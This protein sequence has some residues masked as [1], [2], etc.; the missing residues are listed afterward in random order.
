[1]ELY[2]MNKQHGRMILESVEN[3]PLIWPSIEE[4]GVTKPKKYSDLSAT[5]AIQADCDV[6]ATNII[7]Q[8]LPLKVYALVSNHKVAK[9][10]WE[11][12]Q[13]LMQGT[14][15][16]KQEREMILESV[17]NGPL[18]WPSIEENRV[19]KP[20]KYS[21]LSATE[22]IQAD[23]D[24]KATNIIL[25]GL[26]LKYGSPYQSQQYSHNQSST[27]LS[28]TFPPNDFQSS[29]HHNVYSPSS[30]TP[31][32]EYAP[33]VNQRPKFSQPDSGLIVL[34]FQK[35]DDPIDAINYMMSFLTVVV[36]SRGDTSLAAG[37]S[38]TYTPGAS[39]NNSRK[40]R[41][42]ICYNCK[43]EGHMSK[44]SKNCRSSTHTDCHHHIVA[45]Q[46]N[47]LDAYDSDC[48]EINTAT[49]TLMTN[50][51]HYGSENLAEVHNH[52]N[53][54]HNVINQAMQ[55]MLCSEQSN[56]VNHLETEITS[57]NNII[58]YSQYVS[59]SQ[60]AA[61]QNSNSPAQQDALI[62]YVIEQLKTQV[63]NCTKISLDNKSVN[64]TSTVELERY[65]DQ[66][67]QQLK[68]KLYD[69]NIIEKTNAI[70]IRDS[71]ET[72]MLT[73]ES[74]SKMLLK[75]KDHMMSEKKVNTTLVDYANYVN[76]LEPT[77][78]ARPT[79]VK[80]PKELPKVSM[81]N[82]SLKK[83]KH[84]LASFDVVVKERN[85]ATSITKGT[86]GLEHTKACFRDEIIPFVKA[87]KGLFNSF[88]QF[89]VD[90]L[91]EV[92]NVFHQMEQAVE[93]H[94]VES[95][96]FEVKMNK[97]LSEN[98][99]LL[100]QV[101]SKDIVNILVNSSVNNA[102]ET[103]HECCD[104]LALVD[105]F[106]PIEDNIVFRKKVLVIT[107][108]KDKLRKLKGKAIVDDVVPS[109]PIDPELLKVDVAPLAPKL[110]N[111]RTVHSYYLRHTQEETTTLREIVKQG[112]LLNPLNNSLDYACKYTK[113]IQELLIIIRQTCPC[114][115]NFGDKLMVVTP[116]NKTKRVRFT[117]PVTSSRNT[118]IKTASSSNV[119]SNKPLLSSIGVNLSTSASGSHP[120]GNTK[121]DK[122]QQTPSSTKKNKIK[123]Y[124]RTVRSS[125]INK[126]CVV[127]PKDTT[128]VQHSN[129][130]MNSDLQCITCHGCMFS[131]N[132][133][134]CVLDFI[135]NVN[136]RVK[137]KFAK[138]TVKKKFGN[139]QER[140][141]S[142]TKEQ[143]QALDE[144]L[145]P[146]EQRLM[147]GSCNYRLSTTFKPK[148]PTF[149]VTLD[150]LSLTP[151]Y[152]AFLI[153]MC[154]KHPG[155]KFVDPPFEEDILT[156]MR[157]LGYS[158]HI[159]FLS[160]IKV[161]TLPQPWRTF[162]TL[163]NKC[164]SVKT[165]QAPK[166][167]LGK[168]IKAMAKVA[169]SGKKKQPALGLETL[170]E[171]ALNEAEQLK[172][173]TK[174]S[175]IQTH[176]SHASGSEVS[177]KSSNEEDDD[178]EANIS[179]D[180]DDNDQEDDD[181]TNHDDEARK[182]EEVNKEESFDPIVQN[183]LK[184]KALMMKTMMMIVMRS[185]VSSRFVLNM[186]N[187]SPDTGI[188]STFNLNI[189]LTP[190]VDALVTTAAEPPLLYAI[191][192]LLPSTPIIPHL[193]QTHV[194]L[195]V[196]VPSSSLQ[197][198]PNFGSLFR[199]DHR[200]KTL[201][202]IDNRMN[203]AVKVAV[204][205]Q[206]ERLRDETQVENE[207]FLNKLDENIQKLIKEQL[208][209]QVKA[210][211][212]KILPK[213]KKTVNE[214]LKAEVLTRSYKSSKTSH[215]VAAKLSEL[216]LKKILID[217][218][219]N[220]VTLKRRRDDEDKDEEPS[221]RSNWGFKRRIAGKEQESTSAP[222]KKTSKTTSKSTEGSK[223]HHKSASESA[224]AEEPMH[225]TKDL[226]E[227]AHQEFDTRATEDQP[228]LPATHG[229]IQPWISNLA[230]KDDSNNS[231]NEMMDTPLDFSA[232]VMNRL[233]VDTLTPELLAEVYKETTDQLDW[234]NPEG[235][236][237]LHDLRKPLPLIP[238]SRGRRVIPFDHFINND[239]EYLLGGVSSRKYTTSVTKTKASDYEYIKWI[240]DLVPRT[241]WSQVP[242]SYDKPA[243]WKSH[244]GGE[245][246]NI[247]MDLR[248][249][250]NLL[251]IDD[252]KLYKFK[253][254]DYNRLRIQDIEDMLLL[255]V[256]GKLTNLT[257][258][259][260]F[261]FNVS[262]RISDLKRK[263]AY[264]TYSNPIGFIYQ[265]NDKQNRLMRIDELHKFS[266][267]TLND[268][269][270]ALDDRLK[271]IRMQY[272]PQTIWT[273]SDK[274]RADAMIQSIDKQLK[275]RR[276][277][278][279]LEK[280]I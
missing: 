29:V 256:Q 36:T 271:G 241:M 144:A 239:F 7:L 212:S 211:V 177:W 124:P 278:R 17:E 85:T 188:D 115:N 63:V 126:K 152:P 45:Y 122:I 226:E 31:Q 186:L 108:L 37:T 268:V 132:H 136:A 185:F 194:P 135:N 138:K 46:A 25:Q 28:I 207:D 157:E 64:D 70:M 168:I 163:I 251:E 123:A 133:D 277:I 100:E 44:Q 5:E 72:L 170:T 228:T 193:Q 69:G 62:F 34:V 104:P 143:Q 88:D 38:R 82:T 202:Y 247:S 76:S 178:D 199:F 257:V 1:M 91:S 68:P 146:R 214:Q 250:G 196:N 279:S 145:I 243:L 99:R 117:E 249:T 79:K 149:Q 59:E 93:Q 15:L 98:E 30:S 159:K 32:V 118:N 190:R 92:Q 166:P 172:L 125:L 233:K 57:D 39:G 106:I 204:Q 231:F 171:V 51:S 47:D 223:S 9:E 139:Q 155:Q 142:I 110:W 161:D 154:P 140:I 187:I 237:Y 16:T 24:V 255:L 128:S 73:E 2:M 197:D 236:Q 23:C 164:L 153:T 111:N 87:L 267:G 220:T 18:I 19:T 200:L 6:K 260:S 244:I 219:E 4:N 20:K 84:H 48:D 217:K 102:Y 75:Q 40:Q 184:L 206:S 83:L 3:G 134:S 103:V 235:Q 195:P 216:E 229:P 129:L 94:R 253:E 270:T 213:I 173:S 77:P 12:I 66:K 8:G 191:T 61:V 165:E 272:L 116:M 174:Q 27:P 246:N 74:C 80:V 245:N 160:D 222:N 50:L 265:N 148:E 252:D 60:Q 240:E 89:L 162:G 201:E 67:A 215:V 95:K 78:S 248:L 238:T 58:P 276:I 273:R 55:A 43:G 221:A 203:E 198:L 254:G 35:G 10:L 127:K 54:N 167:F 205:L 264:T 13:L 90:E 86:W 263:E 259:E 150:V 21:D 81:V 22:A 156:F 183:L 137:S 121:K 107:A 158:G 275:T 189:E 109:H 227:P 234:N 269:W 242:V 179:K 210:Q 56:I 147:I 192:P 181:N 119:V 114:I 41:T 65:K 230:Q 131:D 42:V 151:F 33:S 225:S 280:F 11:R 274:D 175:L 262:L 180:E 258:N 141:M 266:D 71:K 26:P 96:T 53:V 218:M 14:S 232:F 113:R 182:E 97:V 176:S 261:T 49:V 224:Q 208:K 112:R 209:E 101:I 169:K 52:N 120:L 130:N 105:K